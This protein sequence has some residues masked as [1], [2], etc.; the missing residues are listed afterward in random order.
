M[1]SP[2]LSPATPAQHRHS[3]ARTATD[4]RLKPATLGWITGLH[5]LAILL[6]SLGPWMHRPEP[7]ETYIEMISL[8]EID[9]GAGDTLED[10]SMDPGPPSPI[11]PS[12]APAPPQPV[13]PPA[14]NP[15]TL[16]KPPTPTP[17]PSPAP[18]PPP[19]PA[20][21]TPA[22]Q[23][24]PTPKPAPPSPKPK[25]SVVKVDLSRVVKNPHA[26]NNGPGTPP[27][28]TQPGGQ[29]SGLGLSAAEVKARLAGKV[30][31]TGIAG[32]T[33]FGK[34]GD[35][36]GNPNADPYNALIKITLER[37]W[38]KP[39]IPE[40]LQTYV[41]IRVKPDGRIQFEGL[42]KSS[43]NTEMDNTVIEAIHKVPRMPQPPPA[44][45]G[46]PD[47]VVSI[48]FKLH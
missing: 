17:P 28:H 16:S 44:G 34:P 8:G 40:N 25:T 10:A 36:N 26:G 13:T 9:P 42:E 4:H 7:Q 22:P 23:P 15:A 31:T 47:Y 11:K 46:N 18:P 48:N 32:G 3:A 38:N 12:H 14:P 24:A 45:L 21:I 43:G 33:G 29:G 5:L 37:A 20:A 41:K 2:S 19:K 6:V 30:G 39:S 35:P 1:P 27:K